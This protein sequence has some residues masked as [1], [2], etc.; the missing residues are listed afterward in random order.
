MTGKFL[1][2][3]LATCWLT[4]LLDWVGMLLMRF[5]V[6]RFPAFVVRALAGCL[7]LFG[8][9]ACGYMAAHWESRSEFIVLDVTA[10]LLCVVPLVIYVAHIGKRWI[11]ARSRR[12]GV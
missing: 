3:L 11:A 1:L 12:S 10:Y 6:T 7:F 2:Y 9:A 4:P 8:A 5:S